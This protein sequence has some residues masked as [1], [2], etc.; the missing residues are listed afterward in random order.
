MICPTCLKYGFP[1]SVDSLPLQLSPN[2]GGVWA[3]V[4][5]FSAAFLLRAILSSC[6]ADRGAGS[7]PFGSGSTMEDFLFF[8]IILVYWAKQKAGKTCAAWGEILVRIRRQYGTDIVVCATI[9]EHH[10]KQQPETNTALVNATWIVF[11][12]AREITNPRLK[13]CYKLHFK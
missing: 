3:E 2:P 8:W 10:I 6:T 7:G 13:Y 4:S 12:A 11:R 1:N 9:V 5:F